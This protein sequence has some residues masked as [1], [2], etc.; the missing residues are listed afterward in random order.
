MA[1]GMLVE[2][3]MSHAAAATTVNNG[4]GGEN[5]V[6]IMR[7]CAGAT[8]GHLFRPGRRDQLTC[9]DRCRQRR[10]RALAT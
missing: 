3:G 4:L 6:G 8:D 2:R 10:R 5:L 1:F 9:S 7:V